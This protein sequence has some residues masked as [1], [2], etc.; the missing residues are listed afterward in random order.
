MEFYYIIFIG[1][2]IPCKIIILVDFPAVDDSRDLVRP[3]P[4]M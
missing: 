4:E 1:I 3:P 2:P